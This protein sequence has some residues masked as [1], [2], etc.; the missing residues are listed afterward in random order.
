[1][2]RRATVV[3]GVDTVRPT[4]GTRADDGLVDVGRL[5]GDHL[6]ISSPVGSRKGRSFRDRT[7]VAIS[8]VSAVMSGAN[9]SGEQSTAS[10]GASLFEDRLQVILD[11]VL[12]YE[13][14][15]GELPRIRSAG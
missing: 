9:G 3:G 5:G 7:Q 8:I 1:M 2:Q 12:G 4:L 14:L 6:L 15:G 13:Q 10:S 11:C